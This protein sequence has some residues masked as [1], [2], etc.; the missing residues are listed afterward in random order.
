MFSPPPDKLS[1]P[2]WFTDHK[3]VYCRKKKWVGWSNLQ[4]VGLMNCPWN[5][6]TS[7]RQNTL[8]SVLPDGVWQQAIFVLIAMCFR[9]SFWLFWEVTFQAHKLQ[10][11][12]FCF[13]VAEAKALLWSSSLPYARIWYTQT[14]AW[15]LVPQ[16]NAFFGLTIKSPWQ[17]CVDEILWFP[18]KSTRDFVTGTTV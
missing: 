16:G 6:A 10:F 17:Y 3:L 1:S 5:N 12:L 4:V 13:K 18:L 15:L 14:E 7:S 2:L 11:E 8:Q 9:K